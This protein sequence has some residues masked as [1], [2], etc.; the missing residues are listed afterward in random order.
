VLNVNRKEFIVRRCE[1]IDLS[2]E[3]DSHAAA[4]EAYPTGAGP[5]RPQLRRRASSLH[6][7]GKWFV[8]S[9]ANYR[10]ECTRVA[11]AFNVGSK[12]NK[13]ISSARPGQ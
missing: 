11:G 6:V 9:D 3:E 10:G 5:S 4:P 13:R 2:I 1:I 7:E 8:C 12:G